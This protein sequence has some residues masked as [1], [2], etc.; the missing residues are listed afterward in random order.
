MQISHKFWLACKK[1]L[2]FVVISPSVFEYG[3]CILGVIFWLPAR[4]SASHCL[5]EQALIRTSDSVCIRVLL[6]YVMFSLSSKAITVCFYMYTFYNI[7]YN[8][9]LSVP[10]SRYLHLSV[11]DS[12]CFTTGCPRRSLSP[13]TKW[14][15]QD[16]NWVCHS[17][18]G[19]T[20]VTNKPLHV[21]K[22]YLL[23]LPF[24]DFD[25]FPIVSGKSLSTSQKQLHW[26]ACPTSV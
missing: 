13:I 10:G 20:P 22:K 26:G 21:T 16:S 14:I 6:S 19:V 5:L 11:P 2:V 23:Y 18:Q 24:E 12:H 9:H 8:L 7:W 25:F 4:H 3:L 15:F 1:C 17:N